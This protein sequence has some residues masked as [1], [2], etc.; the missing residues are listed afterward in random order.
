MEGL[1][2]LQ[3]TESSERGIVRPTV[4]ALTL[5]H[6]APAMPCALCPTVNR[7]AGR[8]VFHMQND[9]SAEAALVEVAARGGELRLV[10]APQL[11][12]HVLV[13]G[14]ATENDNGAC[15]DFVRVGGCRGLREFPFARLRDLATCSTDEV[16]VVASMQWARRAAAAYAR[17][18][19]SIE[20][21]WRGQ[22]WRASTGDKFATTAR[23]TE[24]GWSTFPGGSKKQRAA[25]AAGVAYKV[26]AWTCAAGRNFYNMYLRP[27][28]RKAWAACMDED[29]AVCRATLAAVPPKYRLEGT[30]FSKVTIA[31]DN[32]TPIHT[33]YANAG[34][35]CIVCF[36]ISDER[37]VLQG[38][39]HVL[40]DVDFR[41]AYV[42]EDSRE[43]IMLIGPYASVLHGNLATTQG[44][45]LAI[46]CYSNT[47][48]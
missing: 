40:L 25:L 5:L 45:R 47:F 21:P 17:V 44:S 43:G 29:E 23:A 48:L 41:S 1:N 7:Y 10:T 11:P 34:L 12:M 15:F 31:T 22:S 26:T 35:T 18:R 6:K 28:V 39:H 13:K 14:D 33:D 36:D 3:E 20:K 42:F 19:G 32:P 38:G 30:G 2:T 9:L 8:G 27:L 16:G 24:F 46:S 37:C 4:E